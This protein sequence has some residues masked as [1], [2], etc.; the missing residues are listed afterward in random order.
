M[1]DMNGTEIT[2]GQVVEIKNAF[3]KSDNGRYFVEK[4]PGDPNWCGN[5]YCLRRINKNGTLAKSNSLCFWPICSFV[6]SKFKRAEANYW[7]KQNA[8]IEV[9]DFG[10]TEHIAQYFTDEADKV[11]SGHN[12]RRWDHG[13][14]SKVYLDGLEIEKHYRDMAARV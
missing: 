7:N 6:N 5:D 4:S 11:A 13:E 2:T 14:K 3:F 9:I 12:R 8:T 1:K 10:K